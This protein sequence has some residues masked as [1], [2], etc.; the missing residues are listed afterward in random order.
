M[1]AAQGLLTL[2]HG[3]A[4]GRLRARRGPRRLTYGVGEGLQVITAG[5]TSR[6]LDR[7][8]NDFPAARCGQPLRVNGAQVVTVRFH[9][10]G[11][12]TEN[13]RGV[14]VDVREREYGG[15]PARGAGTA[16]NMAHS[17]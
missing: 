16:S 14:G 9:V 10:G 6:R 3:L 12:R 17:V 5:T 2:T 4:G 1:T 7:K 11:E 15:L 8:P 13:G